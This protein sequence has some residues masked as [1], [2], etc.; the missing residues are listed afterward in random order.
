MEDIIYQISFLN[1]TK[2]KLYIYD[3]IHHLRITEERDLV[4]EVVEYIYSQNL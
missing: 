2:S 3:E 1:K 4:S